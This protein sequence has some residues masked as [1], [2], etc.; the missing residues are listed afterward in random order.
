MF[1][2]YELAEPGVVRVAEWR[3]GSDLEAARHAAVWAGVAQAN[4][5]CRLIQV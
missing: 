3:P 4:A 5:T 2:G 1:D